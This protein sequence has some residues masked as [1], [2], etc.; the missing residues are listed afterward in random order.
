MPGDR[1]RDGRLLPELPRR[2]PRPLGHAGELRPHD[3]GDDRRLPHPGAEATVGPADDVLASDQLRVA[4]DAL[5]NQVRVLDE[6]RR[7]VQHAWD[8]T[9]AGW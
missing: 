3:V 4:A 9:Q 1:Q 6:I 2:A 8:A 5:G 7:R